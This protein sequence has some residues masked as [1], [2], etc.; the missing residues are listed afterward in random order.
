MPAEEAF[1]PIPAAAAPLVEEGP[2]VG[3]NTWA[4]QFRRSYDCAI[5]ARAEHPGTERAWAAI[6]A[7][8]RRGD[9]THLGELVADWHDDLE[10]RADAPALLMRVIA[11]RGGAV[12]EDVRVLREGGIA[13]FDLKSATL[14][15]D[16][17]KG[18]LV[19]F[20]AAF[21]ASEDGALVLIEQART[22]SVNSIS[23]PNDSVITQRSTAG[24]A[25]VQTNGFLGSGEV[26][27]GYATESRRGRLEQRLDFGFTET[28]TMVLAHLDRPTLALTA[29]TPAVFLAKFEGTRPA[30]E[31]E[32]VVTQ[33]EAGAA[34]VTPVVRLL[35]QHLVR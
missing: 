32:F 6:S 22:T 14:Q 33:D 11:A 34:R 25:G 8:V 17:Y 27:G 28:G 20:L 31:S 10:S 23:A 13:V 18:K 12:R 5:A 29:S 16:I 4:R 35:G 21:E 15:P 2:R 1:N 7:C 19:L 24:R 3:S 26:R 30:S 9:F